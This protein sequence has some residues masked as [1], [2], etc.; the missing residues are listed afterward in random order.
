MFV[1]GVSMQIDP[2][3]AI[4]HGCSK[5]GFVASDNWQ[6]HCREMRRQP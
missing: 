5:M 4:T 1:E 3:E 2:L 6:Y